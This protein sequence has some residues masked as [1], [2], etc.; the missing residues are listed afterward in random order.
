MADKRNEP[1]KVNLICKGIFGFPD[2]TKKKGR[3]LM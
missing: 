2:R 1:G 3:S